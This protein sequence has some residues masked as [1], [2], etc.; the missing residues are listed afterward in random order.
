MQIHVHLDRGSWLCGR[1]WV[2]EAGV[3]RVRSTCF[4]PH[5]KGLGGKNHP[6]VTEIIMSVCLKLTKN[7]L[8]GTKQLRLPSSELAQGNRPR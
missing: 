7:A 8:D 1:L 4:L 2:L 3:A 6:E 5:L